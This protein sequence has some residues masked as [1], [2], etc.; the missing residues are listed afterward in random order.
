MTALGARSGESTL[1]EKRIAALR[2]LQSIGKT[3]DEC[4]GRQYLALS[5]RTLERYAR[6][7]GLVF[8]D[9]CP[10]ALKAKKNGKSS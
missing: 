2:H 10:R 1:R 5:E 6:E 7:A 3:L 4:C 8:P 9:Y